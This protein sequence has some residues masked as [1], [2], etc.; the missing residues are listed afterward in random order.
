MNC[1]VL[2][3]IPSRFLQANEGE[4][5]M[6]I[7]GAKFSAGLLAIGLL[8]GPCVARADGPAPLGPFQAPTISDGFYFSVGTSTQYVDLPN[9]KIHADLNGRLIF[10]EKTSVFT[11]GPAATV[12][13]VL[14][15]N[16]GFLSMPRAEVS[17]TFGA[18]LVRRDNLDRSINNLVLSSLGGTH[19]FVSVPN[20]VQPSGFIASLRVQ[21]NTGEVAARLKSDIAIGNALVLTPSI[22]PV[23]NASQFK[24]DAQLLEFIQFGGTTSF[25]PQLLIETLNTW[26]GG[27]ELG[28]GGTLKVFDGFALT[29]SV[30]G[31]AF[32]QHT[33]YKGQECLVYLVIPGGNSQEC[34]VGNGNFLVVNTTVVD[35]RTKLA[36]RL[37]GSV[38]AELSL[39]WMKLGVTGMVTWNNATP[40]VDHAQQG[41]SKAARIGFED[42]F[43]YGGVILATF[44]LN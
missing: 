18:G 23:F 14:D 41:S 7:R 26:R 24:S 34:R 33:R 4:L 43:T 11:V 31:A 36:T 16:W 10:D 6:R 1:L 28:L 37:S 15:E 35:S 29:A 39:G 8:L 5:N 21:Y 9:F 40:N 42:R 20:F 22:G 17:G 44:P 13:Y 30:A 12:G 2:R 19:Q 38:G 27:L 3:L 32:V 25:F